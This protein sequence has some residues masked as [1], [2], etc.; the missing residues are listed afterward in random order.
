MGASLEILEREGPEGLT[1]QA[2]VSR[3]GSSVG[4]FYARFRGKEELLHYLG[5][6]V[7]RESALRWDKA[8]AAR[9]WTGLS[10]SEVAEG[11]VRLLGEAGR[12]RA[13]YL[14]ALERGPRNRD[15][16]YHAFQA[17]V[18][19]GVAGLL[20]ARSGEMDHPSPEVAVRLGLRAVAAILEEGA[21]EE[22]IP[23]E[24]RLEEAARLL[25]GYLLRGDRGGTVRPGQVDFFDIWG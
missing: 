13:V 17:H 18:M 20:L 12:S 14:R 3:A 15:D 25:L 22:A 16:A 5:E 10:L 2:V 9:A 21:A 1:V 24:R 11:A 4:S 7:W 23:L 19:E 8:F 6:R